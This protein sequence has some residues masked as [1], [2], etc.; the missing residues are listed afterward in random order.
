MSYPVA[1]QSGIYRQTTDGTVVICDRPCRML[2]IIVSSGTTPTARVFDNPSGATGAPA[3]E[4]IAL[5]V[6][7]T[8]MPLELKRGLTVVI[9]GTTVQATI[10]YDPS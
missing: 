6:G 2:G 10:V 7:F 4:T 9:G 3:V 8:P 1:N 5:P